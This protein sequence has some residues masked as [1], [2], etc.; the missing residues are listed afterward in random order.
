MIKQA[1][2]KKELR[3]GRVSRK[4][5]KVTCVVPAQKE[6]KQVIQHALPKEAH[7]QE[8]HGT[9]KCRARKKRKAVAEAHHLLRGDL[10]EEE[11]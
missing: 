4:S 10:G 6:A 7:L 5:Q 11:G 8:P 1:L 3:F 2:K 9:S